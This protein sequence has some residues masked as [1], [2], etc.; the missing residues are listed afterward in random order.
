M[1]RFLHL[2]DIHL[3]AVYGRY[4]E[5]VRSAL[6][7]GLKKSFEKAVNFTIE[8]S[9]DCLVLAGDICDRPEVS[10][11]T[12]RFLRTQFQRLLDNNIHVIMLHGNHDPSL[13]FSWVD[14]GDNVHV[15]NS[16]E[17]VKIDLQTHR[18]HSLV[19][20]ANGFEKREEKHSNLEAFEMGSKDAFHVGVMHTFT[21]GGTSANEHDPYMQTTFNELMSKNYDYWALG[22]I[23]K[24][25][26][27][28]EYKAAYSGS[29][30]GL[31][32]N[33]TGPKGGILVEIHA[34][35]EQ[36]QLSFKDFS[37]LEF[38]TL[39]EDIEGEND[40]LHDV[41]K[42]I[43]KGIEAYKAEK[44]NENRPKS[45]IVKLV[46]EGSTNLY[47]ELKRVQTL[48]ELTADIRE[49]AQV[50]YIDLVTDRLTPHFDKRHILKGSPFASF[51]DSIMQ[52][53]VM[54]E[55]LL[56]YAKSESFAEMP[57]AG[58]DQ[59]KWLNDLLTQ[60]GNEWLVRMVD[61]NEN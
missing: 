61:N 36:A 3:D 16:P 26:M 13:N 54:R 8:E 53:G 51:I 44:A 19:I 42:K 55:E 49:N 11:Q 14:M 20:H 57:E 34:P 39:Y 24:M 25:Q 9:L 50:L 43:V 52:D 41:S 15:V 21:V 56:E 27:W 31:N 7:A 59:V 1:L 46:L 22:H 33:E 35:G 12:E 2:S 37:V 5:V 60:V 32:P 30:Q 38:V 58:P 18:G 23:H 48:D 6:K 10:Y 4:P 29:L 17:P 47:S 28:P 40:Q 45:L